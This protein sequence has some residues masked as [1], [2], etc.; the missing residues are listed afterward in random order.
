DTTPAPAVDMFGGGAGLPIFVPGFGDARFLNFDLTG[1]DEVALQA[2]HMYAFEIAGTSGFSGAT[3]W[4]RISGA[5][6]SGG[7]PYPGG[8]GYTSAGEDFSNL[9]TQL[10]GSSRDTLLAVYGV[11]PTNASWNVDADGNWSLAS[12]WTPSAPNAAGAI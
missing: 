9:R 7:N 1:S 11:G 12:N 2:G 3:F 4:A 8:D 10:A 6:P 5:G